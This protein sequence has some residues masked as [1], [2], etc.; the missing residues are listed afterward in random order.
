MVATISQASYALA[1]EPILSREKRVIGAIYVQVVAP[2]NQ[3]IFQAFEGG[4][5]FSGLA[6]LFIIS[7]N[8]RA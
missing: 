6:W 7:R 1:A 4:W 5:I 8:G 2:S 3:S